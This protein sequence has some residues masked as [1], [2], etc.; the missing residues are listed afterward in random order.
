MKSDNSKSKGIERILSILDGLPVSI[1]VKD[2]TKRFTF[3]NRA[4]AGFLAKESSD[5]LGRT[6]YDLFSKKDASRF[7]LDDNQVLRTNRPIFWDEIPLGLP[8]GQE[9]MVRITKIPI[10]DNDGRIA[11]VL[12]VSLDA[13]QIPLAAELLPLTFEKL[14]RL[15]QELPGHEANFVECIVD[16][17]GKMIPKLALGR[18]RLPV[19]TFVG[20]E[21]ELATL[22]HAWDDPDQN[23]L[24][25]I[26]A[27]GGGGKTALLTCW[28]QHLR[29]DNWRGARAVFVWDFY[30]QGVHEGAASDLFFAAALEFFGYAGSDLVSAWEKGERLAELIRARRTLLVLD[31]MER[32]QSSDG[33]EQGRL[34]DP[35]IR[36]LLQELAQN[37]R[38]LCVVTSRLPLRYL[39]STSSSVQPKRISLSNLSSTAG[40]ELLRE[41]G[42]KGSQQVLE[43]IVNQFNGHPLGLRLFASYLVDVHAGDTTKADA[44]SNLELSGTNRVKDI[45]KL[46]AQSLAGKPELDVLLLLG[47]MNGPMDQEALNVLRQPPPIPHLTERLT[48]LAAPELTLTLSRLRQLALIASRDPSRADI[49]DCH[50]L[51]REYFADVLR[52]RFPEAAETVRKRLDE[53]YNSRA[54]LLRLYLDLNEYNPEEVVEI[55]Q[56][57][58]DL[59][60]S[61]TGDRLVI[62]NQGTV[63][64]LQI[65]EPAEA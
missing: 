15:Q 55:I 41:M 11:G 33:P 60:E 61:M 17:L 1:W 32:L 21:E 45:L 51:V 30:D 19:S 52:K 25:E 14:R 64:P 48:S 4:F 47:A 49:V 5:L 6:D 42:V 9:V 46:Q 39:E 59:Y 54:G 22:D 57:L 28:L 36:T 7:S 34:N 50:P 24:V 16:A 58:S 23:R 35:G 26:L 62:D 18:L 37:H 40:A 8:N 10:K 29:S 53:Y 27:L 63:T 12:G 3:V 38:G 31:G 43:N 2:R 20:R 65:P 44:I 56:G 13:A